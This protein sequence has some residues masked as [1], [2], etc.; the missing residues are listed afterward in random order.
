M[1]AIRGEDLT[2]MQSLDKMNEFAELSGPMKDAIA[3]AIADAR[4]AEN[5]ACFMVADQ[6]AVDYFED[7][8]VDSSELAA[9]IAN[10]IAA[11]RVP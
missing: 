9:D 4:E 2:A 5:K 3:Q 1:S 7:D 10:R 8:D 6:M 11:R